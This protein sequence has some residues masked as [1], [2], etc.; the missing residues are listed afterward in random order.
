MTGELVDGRWSI[1]ANDTGNL[2]F[3]SV[4]HAIFERCA[5]HS[6]EYEQF[7]RNHILQIVFYLFMWGPADARMFMACDAR[8]I[9]SLVSQALDLS[10]DAEKRGAFPKNP[11]C[12]D[13]TVSLFLEKFGA[14]TPATAYVTSEHADA[15]AARVAEDRAKWCQ[16]DQI[17]AR[18]TEFVAVLN[19]P[20]TRM[21]L[22]VIQQLFEL[23]AQ[24]EFYPK[25]T[26]LTA[27][28]KD[29][30]IV[31]ESFLTPN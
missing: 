20:E 5:S 10:V 22:G 3:V 18:R 6:A 28:E 26:Q 25:P 9:T 31:V 16:L 29:I 17:S 19:T 12:D 21:M 30:G 24:F 15:R 14:P 4:L 1:G 11:L 13:P 7:L 27:L 23:M 8:T 2:R